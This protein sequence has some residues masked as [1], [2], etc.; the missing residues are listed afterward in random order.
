MSTVANA[1][2]IGLSGDGF[3]SLGWLAFALLL[4][5]I[6]FLNLR[7]KG[8]KIP[9]AIILAWCFIIVMASP[10]FGIAMLGGLWLNHW[11]SVLYS[12]LSAAAAILAYVQSNK[13]PSH[14]TSPK[15][16]INRLGK[17]GVIALICVLIISIVAITVYSVMDSRER[18]RVDGL[19][20]DQIYI[21]A[22]ITNQNMWL[23][24]ERAH[25]IAFYIAQNPTIVSSL[26]DWNNHANRD[27]IRSTL[28]DT[29]APYDGL[30]SVIISDREG[31]VILRSNNPSIYGDFIGDLPVGYISTAS[32]PLGFSVSIP[33]MHGAITKIYHLYSQEFVEYLSS[34]LNAESFEYGANAEVSVHA[35]STVIASTLSNTVGNVSPSSDVLDIVLTHAVPHFGEYDLFGEPY[36]MYFLPLNY[37]YTVGA[38]SVKFRRG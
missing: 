22:Q 32:I 15:E 27:S 25:V 31:Q 13:P 6:L 3:S 9:L 10:V 34:I 2:G 7:S 21:M 18:A 33:I 24:E 23:L 12:I 37:D 35:G 19:A 11:G 8:G 20:W 36:L 4:H 38:I 26:Q 17:T 14:T 29:L 28:I 16:T 5:T 1:H 30:G